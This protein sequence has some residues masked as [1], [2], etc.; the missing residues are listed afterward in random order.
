MKK[1]LTLVSLVLLL[2][3][4]A[5]QQKVAYNTLAS[6]EQTTSVALDSYDALVIKGQI[7]TNDIPLVKSAFN[8]FQ[9]SFVIAL[10][11]AQYNTNAIAPAALIVESQ[12]VIN[13]I[14]TLKRK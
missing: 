11:A 2:G 4:N 1:S 3:C 13:L 7:P 10:D 12:D 14:S 9:A 8:K 5:T 6:L